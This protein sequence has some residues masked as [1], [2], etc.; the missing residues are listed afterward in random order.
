MALEQ[1]FGVR[2]AL[3]RMGQIAPAEYRTERKIASPNELPKPSGAPAEVDPSRTTMTHGPREAPKTWAALV[4]RNT[5]PGPSNIQRPPCR[6]PPGWHVFGWLDA[7]KLGMYTPDRFRN[8][9]SCV[10]VADEMRKRANVVQKDL[11]EKLASMS[12]NVHKIKTSSG[13]GGGRR[14]RKAFRDYHARRLAWMGL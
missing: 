5:T 3:V 12:S 8:R 1:M 6:V 7:T 9:D 4:S 11:A 14:A 10:E 2:L 13:C